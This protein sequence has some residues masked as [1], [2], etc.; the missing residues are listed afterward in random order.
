MKTL[1]HLTLVCT[2]AAVCASAAEDHWVAT[3]TTA[4]LLARMPPSTANTN[5]NANGPRGYRNQTIR[6]MVRTSIPG[7]RL[8]VQL[9]NAFGS[10]PVTIGAAHI[11]LRAKDSAIVEGSDHALAFN[12]K[13]RVTIRPGI[14][15][16]SDP[17]EFETPK[18]ADLAV[19]IF[20][21]EDTGPPTVHSTGLH[22]TYISREGDTTA[23]PVMPDASTTTSYYWL[24]A[25][26]VEAPPQA[27]TIARSS[28]ESNHSWPLRSRRAEP[29]RRQMG[30]DSRRHQ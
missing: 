17:V 11:A 24:S 27:A 6:M 14:L 2:L 22:T 7:K 23:A 13:P 30:D 26:D 3:W 29:V 10:A 16:F 4:Q 18:L 21:P 1:I 25:I 8:R 19:S 12:G 15:I 28:T 5:V 9:S 20:L